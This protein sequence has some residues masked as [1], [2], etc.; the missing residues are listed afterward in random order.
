M[1][2]EQ[3]SASLR[4]ESSY[5]VELPEDP[6]E[7]LTLVALVLKWNMDEM[8]PVRCFHDLVDD[9]RVQE[10]E[11]PDLP[12]DTQAAYPEQRVPVDDVHRAE[13]LRHPSVVIVEQDTG[14]HGDPVLGEVGDNPTSEEDHLLLINRSN[15]SGFLGRPGSDVVH[16]QPEL[17]HV[18]EVVVGSWAITDLPIHDEVVEDVNY[19]TRRKFREIG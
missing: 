9:T 13:T 15:V 2:E 3:V 11:E 12:S 6:Q 5:A 1:S 14:L 10:V 18:D 4:E 8:H 17:V 19:D 16:E 7:V